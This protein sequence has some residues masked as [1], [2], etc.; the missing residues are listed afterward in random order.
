M[1]VAQRR[2]TNVLFSLIAIAVLAIG[3]RVSPA[4]AGFIVTLEQVGSDVVASGSGA[5]DL[6][7]LT[8]GGSFSIFAGLRPASAVIS[9]GST[10]ADLDDAYHG[11][12]GPTNFGSGG[13]LIL[14]SSGSGDKVDL[15]HPLGGADF[16]LVPAGYVSGH[17]LSDTSTY[18]NQTFATLGVTPGIYE[19]TWGTGPNQNFTLEIGVAAVPEPTSLALFGTA[20]VGFGVMRR[21]RYSRASHR[22]TA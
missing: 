4:N 12:T 20:L 9:T 1:F 22:V 13:L 19:W 8:G 21:R 14:A 16:L 7:G 11:L 15:E 2:A 5:I 6:T 17:P 3:T 10:N 18:L